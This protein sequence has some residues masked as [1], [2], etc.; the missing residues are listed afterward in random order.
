MLVAGD[1]THQKNVGLIVAVLSEVDALRLFFDFVGPTILR[2]QGETVGQLHHGTNLERNLAAVG[3][4]FLKA[5]LVGNLH[6]CGED[7]VR[8]NRLGQLHLGELLGQVAV[9]A[10][11]LAGGFPGVGV[12]LLSP[13]G[14]SPRGRGGCEHSHADD[15]CGS[16]G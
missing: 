15:Q 4:N 8:Q 2:G 12:V 1:G 7:G 6:G 14:I 3:T 11:D 16:Q 5:L 10:D 9:G 13:E